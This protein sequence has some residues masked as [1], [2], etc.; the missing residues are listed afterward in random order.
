MGT[1][2]TAQVRNIAEVTTAVAR[3]DL[4]RKITVDVKGEILQLKNTIN[5]MV[6]QLNAFAAEVTRV[7][8]EVGTEGK[9]GGQAQVRGVAGTWK[10]LTDS[11]NVMAANL[12][13]QVRGIVKVVT[14]VANGNLRQKL[15]VQAKGEVAA[16]A[17]TIN[18]MTDTLATFADQVT[19]VA[20][21]VGVEGR[22]GGQA[23]VPGTAGT[24]EDLTANV[25]LLAANLT[26]QVRAIAEVATAVTKGDL[27]RSIQVEARGE[28]AELKD[29]INTMIGN[30]RVTTERNEEQDWLKTNLAKFTRMLQGQ[31]DLVTVGEMLLSELAPLV[32][33]E[34]GTIYQMISPEG[35]R[36][37]LRRLASY[38]DGFELP[39]SIALGKGLVGQCAK[40][41]QRILL[42]DVPSG[43]MPIHSSLGASKPA[44][45]VVL[46]VL[47]EGQTKAVIELASLHKFT[48][49]HLSFLE[50]LTQSIGVVLN[51]I[52]A[53]MRTE[54]LLQQS[55]QLTV[56][57]RAGQRNFNKRM[58]NSSKKP[59]NWL[60]RMQRSN[61]RTWKSNR[62]AAP[63]RKRLP[64]WH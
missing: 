23:N 21:E 30:L 1:N 39:E 11:V 34:R 27:T 54:G 26:T 45:I 47:F 51:T 35:E 22:L 63:W 24:W 12:T 31:R 25:N 56:E 41:N 48:E 40:E 57:L 29:N 50:Q 62:R 37:S 49:A 44:A 33:A 43:Y 6:D 42:S 8:R 13:D 7:A 15:T 20:R 17:E 3:G 2:L 64:S 16:L 4:S 38:A 55:Q 10:D 58:R 61:G 53:T 60:N 9:L 59:G 18:S 14:A 36:P 19:N 32:N 46:P 52:E 5:T 28:V